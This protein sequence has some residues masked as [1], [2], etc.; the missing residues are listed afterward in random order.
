MPA[1]GVRLEEKL[2]S[3]VFTFIWFAAAVSLA[4]I[5]AGTY[6]APLGLAHGILAIVLGHTIGCGLFWLAAYI[7]ARTGKSAMETVKISFG[8]YGSLVFSI[9]NISQLIG[10]T[11]VMVMS[12]A[13]AANFLVPLMGNAG[14]CLVITGLI[15]L[16]IALGLKNMSRIQSLAAVLL[17]ALTI[18][19]SFV[20]FGGAG[21]GGA[22]AG[23]APEGAASFGAAVELAVAMPLSWLPVVSDYTRRARHAAAG[24]T[25][26]TV[27]YF[28]GS[29]WMFTIGLGAALFTGSGD[30]SAILAGAG[31]GV[32]GVL[33]VVFSTVT[34]T[35]FDACSAGISAVSISS[36]LNAKYLGIAAAVL[37]G[38]LALWAPVSDF[39]GF[40]YL[41]GSIF[42]PMA[43]ILVVDFFVLHEDAS[44]KAANGVNLAL[45]AGG[46]LL[47][48][49]SMSWDIVV[50]NTLPVMAIVAAASIAVHLIIR[51]ILPTRQATVPSTKES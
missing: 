47:Y 26:A 42:A 45:W 16:W 1:K 20:I 10:W 41:I 43:A 21:T 49:L 25:A 29:C 27:G 37:G 38:G 28:L 5:L 17:F 13:A 50:G 35:F 2:P 15:I 34:S 19:M 48:R 9:A 30:V 22:A 31:L 33:V 46:F 7:G 40:L 32:A 4:E 18:L 39:E 24:T 3:F 14:W 12:G 51:K 23:T 11:A 6:F 44:S 8:K 36:R